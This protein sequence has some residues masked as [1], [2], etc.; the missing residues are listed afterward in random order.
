[1]TGSPED[2]VSTANGPLVRMDD[3]F[4]SRPYRYLYAG[5]TIPPAARREGSIRVFG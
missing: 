1:M 3:R 4:L 5:N 2:V